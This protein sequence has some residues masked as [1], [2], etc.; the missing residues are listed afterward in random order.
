M[1]GEYRHN[2]SREDY[3]QHEVSRLESEL[4]SVRHSLAVERAKRLRAEQRLAIE[5]GDRDT[6]A[7]VTAELVVCGVSLDE[8]EQKG[9]A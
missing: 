6:W 3:L 8:I 1:K 4:R 5:Q 7:R 2:F 9:A